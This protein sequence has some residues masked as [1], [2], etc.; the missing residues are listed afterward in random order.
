MASQEPI[1]PERRRQQRG[2][3]R[4]QALVEACVHVIEAD[5]LEGVTHRRV[6]VAAGVP[7]AA[8]TYYFSSKEDLM[9][10]AMEHVIATEAERVGV[11]ARAVTEAEMTLEQGVEALVVW[12]TGMVRERKMAQIAEFELFLRMA[13]TAPRPDEM[14]VWTEAFRD[15]ARQALEKLEVPDAEQS[16][17]ALVA[18]VH[19]LMLH[20]LTSGEPGYEERVIAPVLRDWFRLK[21]GTG[22]T[23]EPRV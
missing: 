6:A 14:P 12:L 4:R 18:L 17:Y 10:A 5:G 13:R 16:A 20:A 15:V 22:G 23:A 21:V 9:Q 1:R 19:G 2:E 11:I 3:E 7:L 8:T